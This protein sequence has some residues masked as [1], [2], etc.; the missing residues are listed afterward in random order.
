M[1]D[2]DRVKDHVAAK[3]ATNAAR[4]AR[5]QEAVEKATAGAN[6]PVPTPLNPQAVFL[7]TATA[8]EA[9]ARLSER[10][11]KSGEG[12]QTQAPAVSARKRKLAELRRK[13]A[14]AR[15]E[16]QKMIV[17]E[18][19]R[20]TTKPSAADREK[21]T[22]DEAKRALE[23]EGL[24][25]D[26][27]YLLETAEEAGK[28]ADKQQKKARNAKAAEEAHPSNIDFVARNYERKIAKLNREHGD[29][30]ASREVA[31][32]TSSNEVE[33]EYG[34]DSQPVTEADKER[35]ARAMQAPQ[36]QQRKV[37]ARL[38][39]QDVTAINAANEKY[40]KLISKSFNKYTTELR[41]NLERGTAL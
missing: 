14:E 32:G 22:K 21:E 3:L 7:D 5:E 1:A 16:N 29:A 35:L 41:Q 4:L 18:H 17:E 11:A 38:E 8:D 24:T 34:H 37:Q 12:A 13:Q 27:A 33:L 6:F 10:Q 2:D 26:K 25:K 15:S 36:R 31:L 40:N 28:K 30:L 23:R 9:R 19:R 39:E 20:L